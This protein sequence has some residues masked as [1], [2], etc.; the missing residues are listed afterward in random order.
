MLCS[1]EQTWNA[2]CAKQNKV[3]DAIVGQNVGCRVVGGLTSKEQN[4]G[5]QNMSKNEPSQTTP[6]IHNVGDEDEQLQFCTKCQNTGAARCRCGG[7]QCYCENQGET[8][9][10][11]CEMGLEYEP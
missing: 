6:K 5:T 8:F 11:D 7:D 1:I 9:C 10:P 3:S 4:V 2:R